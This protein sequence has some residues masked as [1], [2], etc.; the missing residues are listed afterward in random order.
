MYSDMITHMHACTHTYTNAVVGDVILVSIIL[1]LA[2]KLHMTFPHSL[3][4]FLFY[5]QTA[6]YA[7]EYF[8]ASF[9][10]IRQYVSLSY[11]TTLF[12]SAIYTISCKTFALPKKTSRDKF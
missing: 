11:L 2:V 7:T 1:L 8:P 10:D 6:Y 9:W 3:K 5:I 4:G 12:S